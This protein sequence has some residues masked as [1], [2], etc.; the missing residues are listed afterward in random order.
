MTQTIHTQTAKLVARMAE[1]LPSDL[2]TQT[3]QGWIDNPQGL[4]KLLRGLV[5]PAEPKDFPT[6]KTITLGTHRTVGDLHTALKQGGNEVNGWAK[7]IMSK[8]AFTLAEEE[9]E[10]QL[11][12]VT[13]KELG[14]TDRTRF[15]RICDRAQELGLKLCPAEVG[16]QMRLQYADQTNPEYLVIAMEAIT[17]SGGGPHVFYVSRYDGERWLDAYYGSSYYL[18]DPAFEFVFCK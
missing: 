3:A 8:P 7:D 9:H 15:D 18:W 16:P 10:L 4:K 13:V 6:W 17:D 1:C 14:F 11:V 5:P 12:K 2:D